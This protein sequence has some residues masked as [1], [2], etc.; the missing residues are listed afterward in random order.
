MKPRLGTG[1]L[2]W[3]HL[4]SLRVKHYLITESGEDAQD[5]MEEGE[6]VY[7]KSWEAHHPFKNSEA[8]SVQQEPS[9]PE[10]PTTVC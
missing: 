7:P 10:G 2:Y 8:H 5:T 4:S 6:L 3:S 1:C 9:H